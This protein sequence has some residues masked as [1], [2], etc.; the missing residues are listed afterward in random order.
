MWRRYLAEYLAAKARHGEATRLFHRPR[1]HSSNS[2]THPL[3]VPI[4][5]FDAYGP[6]R[7]R[8]E[9]RLGVIPH[10]RPQTSWPISRTKPEAAEALAA[11]GKYGWRE[12]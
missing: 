5:L 10:R 8:D 11:I 2:P 7:I 6:D 9:R 4:L 12:H 3:E 1:G